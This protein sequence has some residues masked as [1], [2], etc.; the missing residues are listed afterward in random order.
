MAD[1]IVPGPVDS[2]DCIKEAVCINT[3]KILDSCRDKDCVE[4]VRV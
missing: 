1:R 4:D 3:R 2:N